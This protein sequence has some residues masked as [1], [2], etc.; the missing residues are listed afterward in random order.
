MKLTMTHTTRAELTAE[1]RIRYAAAS[2][3]AKRRMRDECIAAAGY[4]E[5]SA[6]RALNAI[7]VV[8]VPQTSVCARVRLTLCQCR[9]NCDPL[10]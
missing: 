7:P 6:I 8:K 9:L 2:G 5:I 10:T 4:H 3:K 1:V